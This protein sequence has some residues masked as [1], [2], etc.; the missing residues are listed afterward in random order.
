[1]NAEEFD[2][3]VQHLQTIGLWRKAQEAEAHA[4]AGRIHGHI[5]QEFT[6]GLERSNKDYEQQTTNEADEESMDDD[7]FQNRGPSEIGNVTSSCT[8]PS[9][10]L[11][12]SHEDREHL[13]QVAEAG[14]PLMTDNQ[15][16]PHHLTSK[17]HG[18]HSIGTSPLARNLA[19]P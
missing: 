14:N 8:S 6:S 7:V 11:Q 13:G 16:H 19:L 15:Q 2:L 12:A 9:N 18:E 4:V 1:M 10:G 5:L 17:F 3:G